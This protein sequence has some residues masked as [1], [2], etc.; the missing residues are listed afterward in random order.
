MCFTK[1]AILLKGESGTGKSLILEYLIGLYF[2]S[3]KVIKISLDET[4]DNKVYNI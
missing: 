4:I 3:N 2:D 1:E